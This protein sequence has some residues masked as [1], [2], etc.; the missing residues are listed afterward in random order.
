MPGIS[1]IDTVVVYPGGSSG[2]VVQ[3]PGPS[4]AA[5]GGQIAA[6]QV[7]AVPTLPGSGPRAG[8]VMG[9]ILG[10]MA[11]ASSLMWAFYR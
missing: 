2:T 8:A 1:G 7:A 6:A 5:T 9:T 10:L 3:V 11:L 4:A